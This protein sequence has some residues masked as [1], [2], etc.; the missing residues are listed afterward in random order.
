MKVVKADGSFTGSLGERLESFLKLH[1]ARQLLGHPKL[2]MLII[3][4]FFV[5]MNDLR[6]KR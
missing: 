3:I 1:E 2:E 5:F 4:L 6:V